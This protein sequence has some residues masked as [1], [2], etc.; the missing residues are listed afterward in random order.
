MKREELSV[1]PFSLREQDMATRLLREGFPQVSASTWI[2]G[3]DRLRSV[4]A[5]GADDLAG[6]FLEA[7]EQKLGL[8]LAMKS[9][10]TET[11]SVSS[12]VNL[13]SWYVSSRARGQS[14]WMLRKI[15]GDPNTT[16]TDLSATTGVARLLPLIKFREVSHQILY[17]PIPKLAFTKEHSG[18]ILNATETLAQFRNQ[19]IH[20]AMVDHIALGCEIC[21]I[22]TDRQI[23]PLILKPKRRLKL[24]P[25][26]QVIY[27]QS[28]TLVLDNI[29]AL[30]RYLLKKRYLVLEMGAALD[31]VVNVPCLPYYRRRFAK[32]PYPKNGVDYLYSELAYF[33]Y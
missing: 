28:Q 15:C 33:S 23:S 18:T 21:A 13:S 29:F 2:S 16:F 31:Q 24:M 10:R 4:P 8:M 7:G 5:P 6:Y 20:R 19:P 25:T 3:F 12:V 17:L 9:D 14:V 1:R 32:G 11:S 27:C 30:S 26:A 22:R